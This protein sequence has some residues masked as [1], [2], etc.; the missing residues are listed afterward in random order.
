MADTL[1]F[2][3]WIPHYD[4]TG[5]VRTMVRDDAS[6]GGAVSLRMDRLSVILPREESG[7]LSGAAGFAGS[8]TLE[9]PENLKLAG[10]LLAVH[11]FVE[12]SARTSAHL[13]ASIGNTTRSLEWLVA[14]AGGRPE[15]RL[16]GGDDFALSCFIEEANPAMVGAPPHPPMPPLPVT[17][18]MSARCRTTDEAITVSVTVIEVS[19]L[20]SS[21][22][23]S[24]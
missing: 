10:F 12:R 20:L 5:Q 8:L 14:P 15:G 21:D 22:G 13:T 2:G 18:S 19:V 9:M 3:P 1:A 7:G 24:G 16:P 11:G 4:S 6:D 17:V 23:F